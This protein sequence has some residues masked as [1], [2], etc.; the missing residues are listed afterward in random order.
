MPLP[1]L[2]PV[3]VVLV[4]LELA[5]GALIVTWIGDLLGDAQRGFTGTTALIC[6]AVLAADLGLMAILPDPATLLHQPVD[7]GLYASMVHWSIALAVAMLLYAL[8]S[9][10]GTDIAR[11]VVGGG[12]VVCGAVALARAAAAFGSPLLGGFAGAVAILPA[13]LLAGS[14]LA[15]MLLGHWY[16][17]S[18][19]LSFRPL[20]RAVWLIF[21][22]VGIE[23]AAIGLG[24]AAADPGPRRTVLTDPAFWLLAVGAGVVATGVVNGLTWYFAH[25]RANQPATA[26]LYALIIT[27]LMGVVPGHLLYFITRVPV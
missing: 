16:L 5:A 14:T 8:F 6:F 18:P 13:A 4:L 2:A 11:R 1:D 25:I 17:I 24:L 21:L 19:D 3:V 7:A 9:A 10:V 20:R 27:A 23:A 12:A 15:G 22:A 26:M